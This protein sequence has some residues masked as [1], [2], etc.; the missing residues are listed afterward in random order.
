MTDLAATVS[1]GPKSVRELALRTLNNPEG[2]DKKAFEILSIM[3]VQTDNA[4]I[5]DQVDLAGD[6]AFIGEDYAEEELEKLDEDKRTYAGVQG[7]G[8]DSEG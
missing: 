4:D 6:V 5:L 1:I 2:L 3:L 7:Q 8:D